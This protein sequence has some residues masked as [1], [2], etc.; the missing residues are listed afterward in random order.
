MMRRLRLMKRVILLSVVVLWLGLSASAQRVPTFRQY[1]AKVERATA[2]SIDF[3]NSPGASSFRTRLREALRGG[4][5]F[6]GHY[7]VAG[8]G[9]GTGCISG[10][11]ID[12]RTGRVYFPEVM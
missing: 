9:C 10:A 1:P 7:I 11:I 3:K 12:G 4:V 8:W 5:N 2:R 6:A